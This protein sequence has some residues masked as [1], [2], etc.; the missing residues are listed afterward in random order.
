MSMDSEDYGALAGL[1]GSGA[2]ATLAETAY[3]RLG[4]I[5][6]EGRDQFSGYIKDPLLNGT[7]VALLTNFPTD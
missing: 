7:Q 4:E 2:G 6:R 1:L 5:G 3:D